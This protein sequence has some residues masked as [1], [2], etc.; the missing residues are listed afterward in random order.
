MQ[1]TILIVGDDPEGTAFLI[2]VLN[3]D[4]ALIE[5]ATEGAAMALASEKSPDV[6]VVDL[7]SKKLNPL[8]VMGSLKSTMRTAEIP[9]LM[10]AD[11][12]QDPDVERGFSK[13]ATDVMARPLRQTIIR[14]RLGNLLDLVR[15]RKER[16]THAATDGVTGLANRKL[17]DDQLETELLR[18]QR[19]GVPLSVVIAEIDAFPTYIENHGR[20]SGDGALRD[21]AE[22]MRSKV[23]R[24]GDLLARLG[25]HLFACILPDT[26]E[27]G[28]LA[29]AEFFRDGVAN[30]NLPLSA[31]KEADPLSLM[32]GVGHALANEDID[33]HQIVLLAE[34]DLQVYKQALENPDYNP[35]EEE[36]EEPEEPKPETPQILDIDPELFRVLHPKRWSDKG[37]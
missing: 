18:A 17:F 30:L 7:A 34:E 13:G 37:S 28:A 5:A 31:E 24:P 4:V 1:Q 16:I 10:L 15:L 14:H 26:D 8:Q 20:Q 27:S 32:T 35:F 9:I 11:S 3:E 23:R 25:D 33:R 19:R 2:K 29:V 6:I 12:H 36:P 22:I 21:V